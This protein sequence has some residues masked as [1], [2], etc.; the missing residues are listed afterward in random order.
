MSDK[1]PS[2]STPARMVVETYLDDLVVSAGGEVVS[3]A[4]VD[5]VTIATVDLMVATVVVS[6]YDERVL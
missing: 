3:E 1:A 6:L 2:P 5:M 4:A